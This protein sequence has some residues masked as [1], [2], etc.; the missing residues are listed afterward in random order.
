[1]KI[2]DVKFM[3]DG[4][5]TSI[6]LLRNFLKM[7]ITSKRNRDICCIENGLIKFAI[8]VHEILSPLPKKSLLQDE[9]Y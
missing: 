7:N 3:I 4:D 6:E 5:S 9:F 8:E 1:M 2:F